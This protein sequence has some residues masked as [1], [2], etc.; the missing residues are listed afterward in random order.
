MTLQT[1]IEDWLPKE[2]FETNGTEVIAWISSQKGFQ[3][4]TAQL[5]YISRDNTFHEPGWY[6]SQSGDIVKR[7]DLIQGV[8]PWPQ[9]PVQFSTMAAE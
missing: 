6:W 5:Y 1:K 2:Q 7:P 9:P 3:D 4:I 8:Q